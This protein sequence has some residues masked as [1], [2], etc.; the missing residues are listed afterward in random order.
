MSDMALVWAHY[1]PVFPLYGAEDGVCTCPQGADCPPGSAGKH[2]R[3]AGGFRGAS[4]D[5]EKI[6]EWWERWP[7]SNIGGATGHGLHVI[8][9]DGPEGATSIEA[10]RLPATLT[11]TTGRGKHYFFSEPPGFSAGCTQGSK[12]DQL[13]P[14]A[15]GPG[16]DTRGRGGYVV[17][18]PSRHVSGVR[19]QLTNPDVDFAPLPDAVQKRL[20]TKVRPS[21]AP[22]FGVVGAV[23]Q[24]AVSPQ[25]G[26]QFREILESALSTIRAS[27]EG[28]RHATIRNQA[29][30]VAGYWALQADLDE[31]S[32]LDFL[33]LAMESVYDDD[34]VPG[35]LRA[36][37][38]GWDDGLEHPYPCMPGMVAR[39][40]DGRPY[41]V[42]LHGAEGMFIATSGADGG[43]KGSA[44]YVFCTRS[45]VLA[46]LRSEWPGLPLTVP[47]ADGSG[48]RPMDPMTA[49]QRYGDAWASEVCFTY[50][51][52]CRYD[53]AAR[54]IWITP[55][56]SPRP[57]PVR[58][59]CIDLWL[60][61]LVEP[62]DYPALVSWLATYPELDRPTCG[63]VLWG[64]SGTGKGMLAN[65]IG[66]YFGT[67][68]VP[69]DV[70]VKKFNGQLCSSPFVWLDE[71]TTAIGHSAA[72]RSLLGNT[73]HQVEKKFQP[74]ATLYGCPRLFV[75]SNDPDCLGVAED[76][77]THDSEMA[78]GKRLRHMQVRKQ[79]AEYLAR[80]GGADVTYLEDWPSK[81]AEHIEWLRINEGPRVVRGERLLVQGSGI[82]WV[83]QVSS[84]RGLA[85]QVREALADYL[86]QLP[87]EP[88]ATRAA[89]CSR[90]SPA[91]LRSLPLLWH[92]NYPEK[93]LITMEG[94]RA[95]WEALTG[96][97]K[98]PRVQSLQPALRRLA[99]VG[100]K[101][102]R[103]GGPQVRCW[104]ICPSIF[105]DD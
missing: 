10:W 16:I 60:Q 101:R 42:A 32:V 81:I 96:E 40:P 26:Q 46:K 71:A 1:M 59:E 57:K 91:E 36:I 68:A 54:R 44:D 14:R 92:S 53:A 8:D 45:Q 21:K 49:H 43:G 65:G 2:P 62:E 11:V 22:E 33:R 99:Q 15:L 76:N 82:S 79:A 31:E 64:A 5:P 98:A 24:Q 30:H 74:A 84:R 13:T 69:Y 72:F 47:K 41:L 100:S 88:E 95:N 85:G 35:G 58:H 25:A 80:I 27:D 19:Y 18:P 39:S 48:M 104:V 94:L 66:K 6:R 83:R 67:G 75:S 103:F 87:P 51:G 38:A 102:V 73:Q 37:R 97:E 105:A 63:L 4:T 17:L 23:V 70:A 61:A 29:R 77:L 7:D 93:L 52:D 3:I 50:V 90:M 55:G 34:R 28:R 12:G 78:I 9:V 86:E 20:L 89:R 56:F